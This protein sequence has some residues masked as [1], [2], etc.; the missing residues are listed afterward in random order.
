MG[1]HCGARCSFRTLATDSTG[2]PD[3]SHWRWRCLWALHPLQTEA[4]I[5]A[6]QRTELMMAFFYFA[7]LYCSLRYWTV[8]VPDPSKLDENQQPADRDYV[9]R[10]IC[11]AGIGC[12]CLPVR[13]G[14]EGS[15]GLCA[16]H[17]AVV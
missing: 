10:R 17:G 16:A 2:R 13:H 1:D 14:L 4:V 8:L 7:T 15:D 12:A 11:V 3:G 6:T 9:L 5:Y